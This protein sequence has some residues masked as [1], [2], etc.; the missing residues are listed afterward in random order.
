[1]GI[2][3]E[4][5]GVVPARLAS[6][7]VDRG[8]PSRCGGKAWLGAGL[9]SGP[10]DDRS[11]ECW[12]FGLRTNIQGLSSL[13]VWVEGVKGYVSQSSLPEVLVTDQCCISR[14]RNY[15][16]RRSFSGGRWPLAGPHYDESEICFA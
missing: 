16:L 7:L 9:W 4:P 5:G 14:K 2:Q 8:F 1:M 12:S 10:W 3:L 15:A 11:V 13:T 6:F